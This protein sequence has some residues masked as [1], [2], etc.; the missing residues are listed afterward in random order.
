MYELAINAAAVHSLIKI[1]GSR[2]SDNVEI[3]PKMVDSDGS[4]DRNE[5]CP[6]HLYVK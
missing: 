6:S 4:P 5:I 1:H 3:T 2:G